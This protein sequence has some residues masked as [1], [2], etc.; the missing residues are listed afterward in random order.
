MYQG[1]TNYET[2]NVA[3]WI[4]NVEASHSHWR[5]RAAETWEEAEEDHPLSRSEKARYTL[6]AELKDQHKEGNPLSDQPS[7]YSD[8]L[9]AALNE[10]SWGEV[11]N[12]LLEDQEGY[13]YHTEEA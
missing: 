11:A 6:A 7:T 5:E 9:G 13:E 2:W 4:D 10:V 1:W 3:L 12:T 8:L